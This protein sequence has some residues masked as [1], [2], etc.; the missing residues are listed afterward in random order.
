MRTLSSKRTEHRSSV[1]AVAGW[2]AFWFV[3]VTG[4][5]FGA[6]LVTAL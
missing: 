3:L 6:V 4:I 2:V 1:L 5:M